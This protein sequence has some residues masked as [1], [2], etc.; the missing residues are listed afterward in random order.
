M[1]IN[2]EA[3][4]K[5]ADAVA[6]VVKESGGLGKAAD[7]VASKVGDA[8]QSDKSARTFM[9]DAR[10]RFTS[11]VKSAAKTTAAAS[12]GAAAENLVSS[13]N[14]N[15]AD[16][17]QHNGAQQPG[18]SRTKSV[19]NPGNVSPA[20]RID[21]PSIT[22]A[23]DV[24][25]TV[26]EGD[27]QDTRGLKGSS[28]VSNNEGVSNRKLNKIIN[29][30]E[31]I[32]QTEKNSMRLM[33]T[34]FRS[35]SEAIYSTHNA[36]MRRSEAQGLENTSSG[37]RG[38][39]FGSLLSNPTAAG[40]ATL[41]GTGIAVLGAFA[42]GATLDAL[43]H[44]NDNK[45]K[46]KSHPVQDKADHDKVF[47]EYKS[48]YGKRWAQMFVDDVLNSLQKNKG[49]LEDLTVSKERAAGD[50]YSAL[51]SLFD[52][53]SK[54]DQAAI[55]NQI[56]VLLKLKPEDVQKQIA[57]VNDPTRQKFDAIKAGIG[58]SLFDFGAD[59]VTMSQQG[60]GLIGG[61]LLNYAGSALKYLGANTAGAYLQNKSNDF[62][63]M[64]MGSAKQANKD[65]KDWRREHTSDQMQF[66]IL[67][68]PELYRGAKIGTDVATVF[69][70][71]GKGKLGTKLFFG[72]VMGLHDLLSHTGQED[73]FAAARHNDVNF[74][75]TSGKGGGKKLTSKEKE[76]AKKA[77]AFFQS[78]GW[79][80]DQA[81]AI[82]GNLLQESNL[83]PDI[84][85]PKSGA[86]GIA[87]W[88][89]SRVDDFERQEKVPLKGSRFEQ[90]L[91]FVNWE[92]NHSEKKAGDKIKSTKNIQD[93][94]A[95]VAN[96]YERMGANEAMM[97]RRISLAQAVAK[98]FDTDSL[99]PQPQV[100]SAASQPSPTVI[101]QGGTNISRN[102]TIQSASAAAPPYIQDSVASAI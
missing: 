51:K 53:S 63:D 67:R 48:K 38:G 23:E 42:T 72:G 73:I 101:Q 65:I 45:D 44:F 52:K 81:A 66:D 60:A 47:G 37:G 31:S 62:T 102:T 24:A 13:G 97:D 78:K 83:D 29:L 16:D 46:D 32:L 57:S 39:F 82:V 11:A 18:P 59:T 2:P 25:S 98:G 34:G 36:A 5:D 7:A 40:M 61:G 99:K 26:N 76:R 17:Q 84:V 54:A 33:G 14:S 94:T 15:N 74:E 20:G 55:V 96:D 71:G 28:G 12:A 56:A 100:A 70:P 6:A 90:Q 68:H 58:S 27:F 19:P 85:N 77:I 43:T 30:L 41:K 4:I 87:Q 9:R 1:A 69:G 93:A 10:G 21:L 86:R 35:V 92:L 49:F 3:I 50:I 95:S 8:L 22:S 89:G 79:S 80:K 88:L 91:D 75:G 64:E